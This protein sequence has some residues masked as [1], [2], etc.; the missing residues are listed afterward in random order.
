M[1]AI[2]PKPLGENPSL[3]LLIS[4]GSK[5]SLVSGSISPISASVVTWPSP[6]VCFFFYS[7]DIYP[8]T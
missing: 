1:L 8:Q 3:P 2:A 5:S 7:K 6:C 4:D